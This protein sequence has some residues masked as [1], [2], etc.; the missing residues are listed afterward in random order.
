M[1]ELSERFRQAVDFVK[2]NK[3]AKNDVDVAKKLGVTKSTLGMAASGSRTPNWD[4]LLDLCDIYPINFWWLRT[5]KGSMV[6]EDR[7]AA[8]LRRI[9]ELENELENLRKRQG[10]EG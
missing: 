4:L 7:E 6:R 5:G 1:N 10:V 2:K 9:E 3:Y 8:L